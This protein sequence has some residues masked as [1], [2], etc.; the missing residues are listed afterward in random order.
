MAEQSHTPW[1]AS[2]S[3]EDGIRVL[4]L[5]P[6]STIICEIPCAYTNEEAVRD[7]YL[8]AAAPDLLEAARLGLEV[9]ESWIHDQLD[10]TSSLEEALAE[11]APIRAAI[12]KATGGSQ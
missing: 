1:F 11:V 6:R 3:P 8:L 9:A 5:D 2:I 4:A 7:A 12:A 10:G